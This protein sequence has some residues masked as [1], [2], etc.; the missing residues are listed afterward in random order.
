MVGAEAQRQAALEIANEV[1]S[2]RSRLKAAMAEGR[3]RLAEP[4]LSDDAWLRTIKVRDLLL[5]T[6]G[7]GPQKVTRA[8]NTCWVSPTVPLGKTSQK[9][10]LILLAHLAQMHPSVD[11]GWEPEETQE[12]A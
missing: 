6:P 5:A 9:T 12:A 10:R 3:V 8:L 11:L 7:I 2:R 1:R 4:L